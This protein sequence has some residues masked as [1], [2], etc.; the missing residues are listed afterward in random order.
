MVKFHLSVSFIN[1]ITENSNPIPFF[2]LLGVVHHSAKRNNESSNRKR[3]TSTREVSRN[4][5]T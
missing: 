5:S 4:R 2:A 1:K 3:H